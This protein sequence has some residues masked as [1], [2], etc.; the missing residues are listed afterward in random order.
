MISVATNHFA[1]ISNT[2]ILKFF[3]AN[4]LPAWNGI[5]DQNT[6][7]VAGSQKSRRL[8]IMRATH[9]IKTSQ[10]DFK[11]IA[12]LS[13]VGKCIPDVWIFLMTVGSAQFQLLSV[14]HKT[15][16][17][18]EREGTN[19]DFFSQ[20]IN[21]YIIAYHCNLQEVKVRTIGW[22]QFRTLNW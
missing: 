7:F 17:G 14:Q 16:F 22:P 12:V 13:I 2:V 4:K 11:G 5:H 10:F 19:A 6:Q 1:G 3:V 8:W 15:V 18:W 20:W 21:S 9:K